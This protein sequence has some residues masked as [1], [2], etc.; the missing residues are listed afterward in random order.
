MSILK[1]V[2]VHMCTDVVDNLK[3]YLKGPEPASLILMSYV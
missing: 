1:D 2:R 3:K